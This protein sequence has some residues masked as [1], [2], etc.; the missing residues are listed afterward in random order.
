[1]KIALLTGMS[2]PGA[3]GIGDYTRHLAQ[4]LRSL[5][6][7][8][9]LVSASRWTLVDVAAASRALDK[10]NPDVVHLQYP[11][12]GA[13]Y[14][15]SPQLFA[16]KKRAIAT[17]HE[18]SQSHFLRKL[19]LYP[20]TLRADYLIFTSE[21]ERNFVKKLA[22]W[23]ARISSVIPIGSNI[24]AGR[25]QRQSRCQEEVVYFGLIMPKKGLEEV[26]CLAK[27]IKQA[28]SELRV[29]I[30][31]KPSPGHETYL[32]HLREE[33]RDLPV[34]WETGLDNEQVAAQL[35]CS[36]V[37][38]LPFPDGASER[39]GS[40]MALLINGVAVVTTRG[41]QISSDL[42]NVVQYCEDPRHAFELVRMLLQEPL[43]QR[44]LGQKAIDYMHPLSWEGIAELHLRVYEKVIQQRV[45]GRRL[46]CPN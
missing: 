15:L 25:N 8:A 2:T 43:K 6:V 21:Y 41:P 3:C 28:S 14:K 11:M 42:D 16:V 7:E 38:Y 33:S 26:L 35:A 37:A 4:A 30:I 12:P 19:S 29:R 36:A 1:M 44:I 24:N 5:G 39:R 27:L 10:L 20:F 31:G 13:G 22:P 18:A 40:L 23:V 32:E 17:I 46:L 9:E 45:S 34:V